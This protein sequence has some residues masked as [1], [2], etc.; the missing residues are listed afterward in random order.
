MT[1]P[2][3][4]KNA[5]LNGQVFDQASLHTAFPGTT[6]AS[7]VTG[8]T[9]A[10]ARKTIVVNA[11]A[12]GV[13]ALN[14]AV[15]FDVPASTVRWLGFWNGAVFAGCAPNG[16]A[17]PKNF[18]SLTTS[19]LVYCPAHGYADTQKIVFYNGTPPTGITEGTVYFVRDATADTFKVAATSGG[20]AIDLTGPSSFGC[21]VAAITEDVYASQGTHTLS[22]ASV[23]VPD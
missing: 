17:T 7:E 20:V 15:V 10:Y 6:G 16:G 1:W 13:R 22:T 5:M 4:T 18:V 12:G 3:A 8:G 2:V 9:P 19:D 14:T 11:A 23:A 21:V